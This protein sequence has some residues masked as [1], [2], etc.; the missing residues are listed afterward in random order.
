MYLSGYY[1]CPDS[2]LKVAEQDTEVE[3]YSAKSRFSMCEDA[4]T[5]A[6]YRCPKCRECK[7]CKC[8]PLLEEVSRKEE[9]G[10]Q[11]IEDSVH[12]DQ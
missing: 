1:I 5:V 4:G 2:R 7:N 11:I 3:Q 6:N 10:Q 8:G 9:Y 12:F